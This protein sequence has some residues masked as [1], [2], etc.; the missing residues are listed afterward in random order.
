MTFAGLKYFIRLLFSN[1]VNHLNYA[2]SQH[3]IQPEHCMLRKQSK[4]PEEPHEM[5]LQRHQLAM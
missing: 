3:I 2:I 1:I 5:K 4:H